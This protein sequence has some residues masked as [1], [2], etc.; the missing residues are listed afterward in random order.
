MDSM[1]ASL[2]LLGSSS[3]FTANVLLMVFAED[4]DKK[5]NCSAIEVSVQV[6]VN[7]MLKGQESIGTISTYSVEELQGAD[8]T[9]NGLTGMTVVSNFLESPRYVT[10]VI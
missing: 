1:G 5:A 9:F 2:N 6:A 8:V 10:G 7:P 3:Y 4:H